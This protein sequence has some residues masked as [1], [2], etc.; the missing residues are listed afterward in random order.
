M[1]AISAEI[2]AYRGAAPCLTEYLRSTPE[3]RSQSVAIAAVDIS[4]RR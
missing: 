4:Y 3:L 1:I 2:F